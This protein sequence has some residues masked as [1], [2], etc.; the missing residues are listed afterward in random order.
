MRPSHRWLKGLER[1][2]RRPNS[3]SFIGLGRM[4][5]EMAYNLFSKQ[6]ARQTESHFVVCDAVPDSARAFC[7]NFLSNF[8]NANIAIATTPEEYVSRMCFFVHQSFN[9]K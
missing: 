5:H 3:I 1:L 2:S 7:E 4:G 6:Y 8:P 9:T